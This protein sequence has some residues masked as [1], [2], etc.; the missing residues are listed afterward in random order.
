MFRIALPF[1]LVI[2]FCELEGLGEGSWTGLEPLCGRR[3][4]PWWG[5]YVGTGVWVGVSEL[6]ILLFFFSFLPWWEVDVRKEG[7][8]L[9][10]AVDGVP[11]PAC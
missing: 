2:V 1:V 4:F 3:S 10:A 6:G 11:D 9:V 7:G 8:S 5:L